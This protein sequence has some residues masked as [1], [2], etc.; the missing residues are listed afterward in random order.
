[1][2]NLK[3]K[4]I[5]RIVFDVKSDFVTIFSNYNFIAIPCSVRMAIDK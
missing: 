4:E 3:K 5:L 2:K 1:M